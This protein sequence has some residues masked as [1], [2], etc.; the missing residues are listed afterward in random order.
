[1]IEPGAPVC[2]WDGHLAIDELHIGGELDLMSGR[3][4]LVQADDGGR[5]LTWEDPLRDLNV[6]TDCGRVVAI[7]CR[8]QFRPRHDMPSNYVGRSLV[9]LE[10]RLEAGFEPDEI[11]RDVYFNCDTHRLS[12]VAFVSK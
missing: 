6:L 9:E 12:C 2:V 4:I 3:W 1:M 5:S 10:A 7:T 11:A 8:E